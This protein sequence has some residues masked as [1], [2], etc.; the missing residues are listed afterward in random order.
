VSN[1]KSNIILHI[2]L[3]KTGSTFIQ[4]HLHSAKL[5]DYKIFLSGSEIV[6]LLGEY[7]SNP[8]TKIKKKNIKYYKK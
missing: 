1:C 4:S 6:E 8:N 7:L 2:G 5:D 3:Y